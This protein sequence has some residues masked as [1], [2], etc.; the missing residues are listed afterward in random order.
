MKIL[1]I[2]I[3]TTGFSYSKDSIVEVGSVSLDL[4]SGIVEDIF[5]HICKEDLFSDAHKTAWVFENSDLSFEIIEKAE[6]FKLIAPQFQKVI[7]DHPMGVTSFGRSFDIGFLSDRGLKFGKLL[8]CPMQIMRDVCRIPSKDRKGYKTPSLVE[9]YS[10]MFPK[11]DYIEKH[12]GLDDARQTAKIIHE[13][14]K[15]RLFRI[16]LS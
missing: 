15:R 3:E 1:I 4:M 9:A 5:N 16:Q 10:Y 2:D 7:S 6:D 13:L 8:D 12:R 11:C 14:Y